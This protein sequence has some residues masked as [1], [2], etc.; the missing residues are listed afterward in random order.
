MEMAKLPAQWR[1]MSGHLHATFLLF[2]GN[3]LGKENS[4]QSH[5]QSR[6]EVF[7]VVQV[8]HTAFHEMWRKYVHSTVLEHT[9]CMSQDIADIRLDML[10]AYVVQGTVG[11][12]RQGVA[13]T[14]DSRRAE[15]FQE[16]SPGGDNVAHVQQACAQ[17]F[18]VKIVRELEA[19]KV[20]IAGVEMLQNVKS[21]VLNHAWC[22]YHGI[23]PE[24]HKILYHGTTEQALDSI[25]AEGVCGRYS[26]P[27]AS[28]GPGVYV[29]DVFETALRFSMESKGRNEPLVVLVLQCH[30]GK[31]KE[32][33]CGDAHD[34]M[35]GAGD[36]YNTK[37]NA[38]FHHY[39]LAEDA[40]I[41]CQFALKLQ[42]T[43]GQKNSSRQQH[44]KRHR[45]CTDK[46]NDPAPMDRPARTENVR[47]F[48]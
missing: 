5:T 48:R 1:A 7:L 44:R 36:L 42:V 30:L 43:D 22:G 41:V 45:L 32:V 18:L 13:G 39:V 25:R 40:Q 33:S 12:A 21:V 46:E 4:T 47:G 16:R 17:H 8:L 11:T 9:H 23:L 27:N 26:K 14:D 2:S 31:I 38:P 6:A 37:H 15:P 20:R 24:D 10:E 34:F 3:D 29:T 28:D 35:D 19:I